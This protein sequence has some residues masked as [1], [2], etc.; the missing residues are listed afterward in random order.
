[1][2][3]SLGLSEVRLCN[4]RGPESCDVSPE[5]VVIKFLANLRVEDLDVCEHCVT[6]SGFERALDWI[7]SHPGRL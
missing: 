5:V 1:M 2:I 4:F 7:A 3:Q 6:S